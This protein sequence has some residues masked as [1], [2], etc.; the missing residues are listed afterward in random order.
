MKKYMAEFV[1]TA[2]LVF[3]GC[4]AAALHKLPNIH[5]GIG[6]LG[7]A[8]AFGLALMVLIYSIGPVS[9]CHVNPAVSLS[10]MILGRMES[11]DFI[12]YLV[13][14]VMGAFVGAFMLYALVGSHETVGI[15]EGGFGCNGFGDLSNTKLSAM[16]AFLAEVIL[17][18]FFVSTVVFISS[19]PEYT[20]IA[21]FI[22]GLSLALVHIV[23][24]PLTGTSVNPARS[25]APACL[26]GGQALAQVWV[27]I[28]APLV[29]GALA[30]FYNMAFNN[31]E[32]PEDQQ[33]I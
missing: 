8:L 29:G 22:I 27:F 23:G 21:G 2:M 5:E 1:G 7:V 9:G 13:A 32:V 25:L 19:K 12:P 4:G 33:Q 31:E 30:A 10:M 14:Q 15:A 18:F 20:H 28:I 26:K 16:M 6:Y 11:K 3:L 17:T 24:L